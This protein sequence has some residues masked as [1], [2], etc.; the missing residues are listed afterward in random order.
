MLAAAAAGVMMLFYIIK[1]IYTPVK[2]FLQILTDYGINSEL[3]SY[4]LKS[5]GIC[6]LTKFSAELCADFGQSSLSGKVEMAGKAALFILSF[7][8]IKD[9]LNTGLSLL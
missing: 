7:P 6:F 5:L 9:I 4:L 8:L 1:Q 2:D 3:I